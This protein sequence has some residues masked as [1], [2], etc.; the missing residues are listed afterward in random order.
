LK[1]I[2]E[3]QKEINLPDNLV[4]S[5]FDDI[6]DEALH[7]ILL[8]LKKQIQPYF[9]Q[10]IGVR[11]RYGLDKECICIY[12]KREFKNVRALKTHISRSHK[13]QKRKT[14]LHLSAHIVETNPATHLYFI[15]ENED[16][17]TD[18]LK[19]QTITNIKLKK[20]ERDE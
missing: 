9:T 4:I 5:N 11:E 17:T 19:H 3:I 2:L 16:A 8:E 20:R 15:L 12:C 10:E 13:L 18:K 14:K 6:T 7:T 1:L